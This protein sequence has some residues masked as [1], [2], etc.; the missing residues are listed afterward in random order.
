[1]IEKTALA[2][3][4]AA[5]IAAA[6]ALFVWA[7]GFAI[8]LSLS[9]PFGPAGA[10]AATAAAALIVLAIVFVLAQRAEPRA[11]NAIAK[12]AVSGASLVSMFS[13]TIKERPLLTLGLTALTG[14]AA[15]RDKDLLKDLWIAVL[16]HRDDD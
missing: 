14:L 16:H 12:G 11:K 2:L 3:A 15:T 8:Y 6:A 9:G 1:L 4:A 5:V 13:E 10:A 7:G